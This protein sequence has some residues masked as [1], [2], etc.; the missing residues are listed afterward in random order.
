VLDI[1]NNRTCVLDLSNKRTYLM[2]IAPMITA[3]HGSESWR[4][5]SILDTA[6]FAMGAAIGMAVSKT[7]WADGITDA[8]P[9]RVF[10]WLC[11][12]FV[13][14][15]PIAGALVIGSHWAFRGR[16]SAPTNGEL[17]WISQLSA[18][19]LLFFTYKGYTTSLLLLVFSSMLYILI[20]VHVLLWCAVYG[21]KAGR[22]VA[23]TTIC[24]IVYTI[25]INIGLLITIIKAALTRY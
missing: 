20:C 11:L 4:R 15:S 24:G 7:F 19:V 1:S 13:I 22:N 6:I 5:L 2:C 16:R 14:G 12:A 17:L 18:V 9:T 8:S 10:S 23:W 25:V 21:T 3:D